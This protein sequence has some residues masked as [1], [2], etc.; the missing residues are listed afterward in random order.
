M[1]LFSKKPAKTED[2]VEA[3]LE[4]LESL[5]LLI[6]QLPSGTKPWIDWTGPYPVLQLTRTVYERKVL[7]S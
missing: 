2:P 7:K 3:T 6:P 1:K 5:N 4:L